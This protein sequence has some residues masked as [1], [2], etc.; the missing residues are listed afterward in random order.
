MVTATTRLRS[1]EAERPDAS[2]QIPVS[3]KTRPVTARDHALARCAA[4]HAASLA[5]VAC[6]RIPTKPL[7]FN[8]SVEQSHAVQRVPVP[9]RVKSDPV[10]DTPVSFPHRSDWGNEFKVLA[11]HGNLGPAGQLDR[12]GCRS[13]GLPRLLFVRGMTRAV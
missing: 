4:Y 11:G 10:T 3:S 7:R 8:L 12:H 9:T 6:V 2:N 13:S 5:I 1:E